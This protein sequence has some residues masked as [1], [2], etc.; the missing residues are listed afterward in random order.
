[1]LR[2]ID[3]WKESGFARAVKKVITAKARDGLIEISFPRVASY[4]AVISAI[5]ISTSDM[6]AMVP[7]RAQA[8]MPPDSGSAVKTSAGS[9]GQPQPT[10]GTVYPITAAKK[11]ATA[12]AW[13]IQLGLGGNHDF[14]VC[15]ANPGKQP[16][17]VELRVTATDGTILGQRSLTLAP[18]AGSVATLE[19]V[20]MNAGEYTVTLTSAVLGDLKIESLLVK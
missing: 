20:G 7:V 14:S 12:L 10:E 5:A 15:Y 18:T 16:V 13:T 11:S 8:Q 1:V 4:Q 6:K 19:G 9:T 2:D 17:A 3:L